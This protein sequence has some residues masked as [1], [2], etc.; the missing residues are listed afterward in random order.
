MAFLADCVPN[1]VHQLKM[2]L[3]HQT[4]LNGGPKVL[5][6]P[7]RNSYLVTLRRRSSALGQ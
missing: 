7:A 5:S 6:R 4:R 1:E 2:L 3:C